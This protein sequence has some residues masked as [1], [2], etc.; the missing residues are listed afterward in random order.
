MLFLFLV[1]MA[2]SDDAKLVVSTFP[3]HAFSL[4]RSTGFGSVRKAS[5]W[6]LAVKMFI[7]VDFTCVAPPLCVPY[8]T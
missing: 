8:Y 5:A 7:A 6:G 4:G 3:E 1:V 2:L